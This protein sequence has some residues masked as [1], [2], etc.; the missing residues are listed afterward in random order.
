MAESGDADP[1]ARRHP[2]GMLHLDRRYNGPPA[3]A[4]GGYACGAVAARVDAP[5]AEVTL[6]RPVPLG[7]PLTVTVDEFG[8]VLLGDDDGP[9]ADGRPI[10][11]VAVEPPVR[12][13][14]AEARAASAASPAR[15][16][17]EVHPLPT[18]FV[19]GVDGRDDG[20]RI[21]TG[22]LGHGDGAVRAAAWRPDERLPASPDG[23]VPSELVWAAL[24]CPSYPALD[25][26]LHLLGRLAAEVLAPVRVGEELAVVGWDVSGEGRKRVTA[27]A[28]IDGAGRVRARALALW[29]APR[30]GLLPPGA[31]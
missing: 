19:C 3:S 4:N 29:I 21:H 11:A 30:G 5:A 1:A 27:S 2:P 9:I 31:G 13:S 8:H 25:G 17:P 14:F 10:D 16:R 22:P 12:P 23:A 26:P 20:L 24:D 18:C 15:R 28:V 7:R 6:L